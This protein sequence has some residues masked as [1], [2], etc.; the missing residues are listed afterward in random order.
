MTNISSNVEASLY[1]AKLTLLMTTVVRTRT[2]P[3]E[4]MVKVSVVSVLS[5]AFFNSVENVIIKCECTP[6]RRLSP[7]LA[8]TLSVA[9]V[10]ICIADGYS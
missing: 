4:S 9:V 3:D 10:M 8:V 6:T 1:E 5:N 2:P 7:S